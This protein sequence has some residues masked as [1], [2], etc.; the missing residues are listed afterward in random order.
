MK[1]IVSLDSSFLSLNTMC[2]IV[3]FM[4]SV[5]AFF[6]GQKNCIPINHKKMGKNVESFRKYFFFHWTETTNT[7]SKIIGNQ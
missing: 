5:R 6:L 1:K 3:N 2:C 4:S 7:I